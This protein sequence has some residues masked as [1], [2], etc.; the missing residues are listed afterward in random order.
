MPTRKIKLKHLDGSTRTCIDD[1]CDVEGQPNV[2]RQ[3]LLNLLAKRIP[4]PDEQGQPVII[5]GRFERRVAV[6]VLDEVPGPLIYGPSSKE[7]QCAMADRLDETLVA[8]HS[9]TEAW[10]A[11]QARYLAKRAKRDEAGAKL[12]EEA[13]MNSVAVSMRELV[14]HIRSNARDG[15][16]SPL[17][18][19]TPAPEVA[20][21]ARRSR[22]ETTA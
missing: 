13:T 12:A 22:V 3:Q 11:A 14:S 6:C 15:T 19:A 10:S 1:G 7:Q 5:G 9:P 17:S 20:A 8:M 2:A 21:P 18:I 16:T 4:D